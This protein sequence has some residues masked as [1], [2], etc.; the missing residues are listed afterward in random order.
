MATNKLLKRAKIPLEEIKK[1]ITENNIDM[2]RLEYMDLLGIN[3]GKLMPAS[4]VDEIFENGINFCLSSLSMA[5]SNDIVLS[6]Y[7]PETNE[8]MRVIGDPSTFILL[9]HCEHTALVL[10]DL[11]YNDKP[12]FQAPREFLKQ[13]TEKYQELGFDPIAASELEFF[14]YNK[15]PDGTT[16]PYTSQACT[17][18]QANRRLDKKRFLY[19]LTTT[20]EKLGFNVLYMNHE[21][22]PGQFEYNWK[23]ANIIQ[24]ADE[25]AL[26]KGFS[27]DIAEEEDL[28]VTFMAKPKNASGGSGCHFHISLNDIKTGKNIFYD[29]DKKDGMSETMLYF[30][31]GLIKHAKGISAFLAPTVNCYK[32]YQPDSFAPVYI[33]WGYD[34][35]T[36]YIRVPSERKAATRVEVRA[37]S[38]ASNPYLALGAILAAGLD[39]IKNKITAP[40]AIMTDVY[41]DLINQTN[42]L[43]AS[44]F[45]ALTD[46][47]NDEWI[48]NNATPELVDA[49]TLLKKK[50]IEEYKKYVTDW[51]WNTYSYHI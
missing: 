14:I 2:I 21:Y 15:L 47:E 16:E 51:E 28:M 17:C 42:K 7:F 1:Q 35:R 48:V 10:G 29:P 27:K 18:Y 39:G 8:D 22:F 19:K 33:G 12:L 49:F 32:R 37:A 26:F 20:F 11:Y 45:A 24:A 30:I 5:F 38:A 3:R 41:H 13:M 36:T 4:M 50:E 34:N 6:K 9:P 25:S 46:L 31:G 40:E 43:P 23:H 44:L